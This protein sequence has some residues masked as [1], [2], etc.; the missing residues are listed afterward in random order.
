MKLLL[1]ACL[2][3]LPMLALT[4][5]AHAWGNGNGGGVQF[6][7]GLGWKPYVPCGNGGGCGPGGGG[8]QLGPWY[9]YWPYD[10]HFQTPAMPQYPFW[11]G[12]MTSPYAGAPA[13]CAPIA[14]PA[15]VPPPSPVQGVGYYSQWPTYWYGH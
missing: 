12:P 11:P 15:P 7:L 3:A 8:A 2:L 9:T 5:P 6:C 4:A 1:K 10:A 14:A 13:G